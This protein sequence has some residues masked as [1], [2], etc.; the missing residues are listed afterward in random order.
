MNE[1]PGPMRLLTRIL[2]PLWRIQRLALLSERFY[3]DL[4]L[5]RREEDQL[6]REL[7]PDRPLAGSLWA[8]VDQEPADPV[9]ILEVGSGPIATIGFKHP[10]R[11]LQI[12]PTDVLA[13]E[14][15]RMLRRRGKVPP[16]PTIYADAERLTAQFGAN[17]FNIVYAAN[18]VDHMRD[19]LTAIRE[20]ISVARLGGYVVL[21]HLIDEGVRQ[22][23]S[24]LHRWNLRAEE[25][26]PILWN[27][28]QRHDLA[29]LLAP[30]CDVRATVMEDK[31]HVEIR[32]LTAAP[33]GIVQ[34]AKS[35]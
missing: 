5:R 9:T 16:I 2:T 17:T 6:T 19:P 1:R 11:R 34:K 28:L 23:Y 15:N 29:D 20:M 25:G 32:K 12:T 7:D 22:N 14:Y 27:R 13:D 24:G 21:D 18:C 4:F 8:L 30:S 33:L 10:K 35:C 3:W 31:V 26:R